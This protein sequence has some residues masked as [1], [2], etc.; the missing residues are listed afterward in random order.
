MKNI[1]AKVKIGSGNDIGINPMKL[2][3]TMTIEELVK[4]CHREHVKVTCTLV[5][6]EIGK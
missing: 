3:M 1:K 4:I 5:S 6:K 2:P